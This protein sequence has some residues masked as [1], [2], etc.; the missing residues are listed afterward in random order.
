MMLF[1]FIVFVM[2]FGHFFM[3]VN[4]HA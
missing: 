1:G 4:G 3:L 2:M